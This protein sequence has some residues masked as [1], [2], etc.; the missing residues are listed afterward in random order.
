MLKLQ[1]RHEHGH[2][3]DRFEHSPNSFFLCLGDAQVEAADP[4]DVKT[5]NGLVAAREGGADGAERSDTAWASHKQPPVPRGFCPLGRGGRHP[6][7]GRLER[8]STACTRRAFDEPLSVPEPLL[9]PAEGH[10]GE[11]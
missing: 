7:S 4:R 1:R 5:S 8:A 9:P 3:C 10:V 2:A 11:A 6:S